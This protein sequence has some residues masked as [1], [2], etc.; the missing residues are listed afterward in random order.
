[1]L[2][3]TCNA[4]GSKSESGIYRGKMNTHK[5]DK[6]KRGEGRNWEVLAL[7]TCVPC[8]VHE[9]ASLVICVY[10]VNTVHGRNRETLT[11]PNPCHDHAASHRR[12]GLEPLHSGSAQ[13]RNV[14]NYDER[15]VIT[16]GA[17]GRP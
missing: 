7:Y 9:A 13:S 6:K 17:G 16:K 5:S 10:L 15:G 8:T 1:M 3:T 4:A 12:G 11:G 2:T 14:T